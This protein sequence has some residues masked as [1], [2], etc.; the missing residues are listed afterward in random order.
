MV[1]RDGDCRVRKDRAPAD[2]TPIKHRARKPMR[3]A[4][5]AKGSMCLKRKSAASDDEFRASLVAERILH[6]IPLGERWRASPET[7]YCLDCP[8]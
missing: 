8:L 5:A 1:F 3:N 6:P 2:F 7:F 4:A